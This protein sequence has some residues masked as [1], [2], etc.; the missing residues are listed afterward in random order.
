MIS[1]NICIVFTAF[2]NGL[3]VFVHKD[4]FTLKYNADALYICFYIFSERI[5]F[6]LEWKEKF[7]S[8]SIEEHDQRIE[9]KTAS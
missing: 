3:V 7:S 8:N 4:N 9:L 6:F 1:H 2:A 5:I